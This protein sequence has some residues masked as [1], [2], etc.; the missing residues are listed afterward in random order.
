MTYQ[1]KMDVIRLRKAANVLD[2]AG[3]V[4]KPA[5]DVATSA[6][7]LM[8]IIG[9]MLG[10]GAGY[11]LS[12]MTSPTHITEN[13][14]KELYSSALTAEIAALQRQLGAMKQENQRSVKRPKHDQFV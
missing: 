11:G 2:T 9:P 6:V 8:H 7:N 5:A 12:R 4:V 3:K 1:E 14:D 10:I 13:A